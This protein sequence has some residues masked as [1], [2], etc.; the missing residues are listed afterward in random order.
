MANFAVINPGLYHYGQNYPNPPYHKRR[1]R[2]YLEP[3]KN[4]QFKTSVL[5]NR[6]IYIGNV[7]V[8]YTDGTVET[9]GDTMFKS[10]LGNFDRFTKKGRI[11]VAVGDGENIIKLETYAD[12]ILQFK[13]KTLHII[14]ASGKAE[15]LEDSFK[16]KG[17]DNSQAVARTDFGIAWVNSFGCYIYD[18]REIHDLLEDGIKR[19]INKS[20]WSD[21]ISTTSMVGYSPSKRQI[22]IVDSYLGSAS[23]GDIYLYDIPTRSWVQGN[24]RVAGD[25]K[26]NFII[27]NSLNRETR[28]LVYSKNFSDNGNASTRLQKWLDTPDVGSIDLQLKDVDFGHPHLRKKIHKVYVTAKKGAGISISAATNGSGNYADVTFAD[29]NNNGSPNIDLNNSST[30]YKNEFKIASGGNN[31]YSIQLKFSG[32]SGSSEFSINDVSIVYRAKGVK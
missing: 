25:D 9:L 3:F 15:F 7:K 22:I 17:V 24:A 32:T 4:V 14:N 30:W 10:S 1:Y 29:T 27:K 6:R 12:R 20:T 16:Y 11:D 21:F 19:K 18:G 8:T 5:H 26:S 13:D 31:V 2:D 23:D 28:E